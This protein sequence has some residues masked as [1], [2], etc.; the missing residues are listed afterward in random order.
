VVAS[1]TDGQGYDETVASAAVGPVTGTG[2]TTPPEIRDI[3]VSP[4]GTG[5]TISWTTDENATSVVVYGLDNTYGSTEQDP[6]PKTSHSL[7]INGLELDTLYHYEVRSTDGVG[8]TA[9]SGDRFFITTDASSTGEDSDGDG[10]YDSVD[11]C[12]EIPDDQTDTNN[13]GEGDACDIDDDGDGFNDLTEA[14]A[15]SNPLDVNS[16]PE[17][18]NYYDDDDDG[19][20][21]EGFDLDEDNYTTC[22]A[23]GVFGTP[24]DDCNDGNANANPGPTQTEIEGDGI[25]ND[26]NPGT[27]DQPRIIAVDSI[28]SSGGTTYDYDTWLP[29]AGKTYTISFKVFDDNAETTPTSPISFTTQNISS[30]AG[31]F[32]NDPCAEDSP[33]CYDTS[34]DYDISEPGND[35]LTLVSNDYGGSAVVKASTTIDGGLTSVETFISFPRDVDGDGIADAWEE[36]YGSTGDFSYDEDW[37][38]DDLT[39]FEEFRGYLWG[40]SLVRIAA[41]DTPIYQTAAYVPLGDAGHFRT[42]PTRKDLFIMYSSKFDAFTHVNNQETPFAL[43]EAYANMGIDVHAVDYPN[44]VVYPQSPTSNVTFK[45]HYVYISANQTGSYSETTVHVVHDEA[46]GDMRQGDFSTMGYSNE[47]VPTDYGSATKIYNRA[48]VNYFNDKPY[49]EDTVDPI[50]EYMLDPLGSVNDRNDNGKEDDGYGDITVHDYWDIN[51]YYGSE[52][53]FDHDLTIFDVDNDGFM[54]RPRD[55]Y[56]S[57]LNRFT[58]DPGESTFKQV[59]KHLITHEIGHAVGLSE[60]HNALLPAS[61]NFDGTVDWRRD[62]N[63]HPDARGQ[64]L[65]HNQ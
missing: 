3:M 17:V 51:M 4:N 43:G 6:T 23:D 25:D 56:T 48:V 31:S 19:D 5:A 10:Y 24:D 47:G 49:F 22:G 62:N 36:M 9:T 65:I 57:P 60:G 41:T 20:T 39:D 13:D 7:V 58:L 53:T 8:N 29:E 52:S 21:D 33:P 12:M 11:V 42:N 45:L 34:S 2:D 64:I 54:D 46:S 50:S 35:Q 26:C 37:D 14:L 59:V 30:E 38:E 15:G 44:S 28:V 16:T 55:N 18:C 61:L 32:T 1:Y 27:P 63:I 40:P